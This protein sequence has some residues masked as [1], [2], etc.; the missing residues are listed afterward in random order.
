MGDKLE[1]DHYDFT[2]DAM[3]TGRF[4]GESWEGFFKTREFLCMI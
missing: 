2:D 4:A 3:K 1:E